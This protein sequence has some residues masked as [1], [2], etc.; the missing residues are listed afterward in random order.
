MLFDM[1]TVVTAKICTMRWHPQEKNLHLVPLA[2]RTFF[3]LIV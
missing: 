2:H 3:I 1:L